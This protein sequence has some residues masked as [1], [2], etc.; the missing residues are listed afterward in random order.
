MTTYDALRVA[1]ISDAEPGRNGVGTY[2]LD[3]ADHLRGHVAAIECLWPNQGEQGVATWASMPLPGDRTQR[4]ELPSPVAVRQRLRDFR[5]NVV[6]VATPGAYGLFG[7]RAARALRARLIVGLHT[8]FEALGELYGGRLTGGVNRRLMLGVH[9]WLLQRA[10]CVVA[11]GH[12]M[13]E[14]ARRHGAADA[15]LVGTQ[16]PPAF[17]DTPIEPPG[18]ELRRIIYVGRLA[19]EKRVGWVIAAARRLP[20]MAFTIAGDGPLRAEFEAAA[21]ELPNLDYAGWL[22]RDQ[23]RAA[24]DGADL[25][26]LPSEIEAFGTVA[27]EALA[28]ERL[29][30]VSPGCGIR[31]WPELAA[32]L[33]EMAA[34]EDV[35]GAI[36]RLA[37]APAAE[38]QSNAA[39]GRAAAHELN[40]ATTRQWLGILNGEPPE[41]AARAD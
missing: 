16:L 15:R 29:A 10:D 24:L 1:I 6:V 30:L 21:R 4:L 13:V 38:R 2:Y 40:A 34:D 9:R 11:N 8:D 33:Y 36:Q 19:P 23:I 20:G 18:A 37:A 26:V 7:V 5:P 35:A 17:L 32:G 31:N 28:R 12:E 25:L 39:R 22:T 14:L 27:L 41:P 3:L